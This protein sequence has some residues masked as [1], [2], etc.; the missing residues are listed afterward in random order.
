VKNIRYKKKISKIITNIRLFRFEG[1]NFDIFDLC[2]FAIFGSYLTD[3][4]EIITK[5]IYK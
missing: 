2:I 5:L 4:I 3:I 1:F